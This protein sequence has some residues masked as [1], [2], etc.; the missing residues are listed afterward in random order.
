MKE[1]KIIDSYFKKNPY[2]NS[3]THIA[4]GMGIGVLVT[5]PL[6]GSHPVR[7]GLALLALGLAG[8]VYPLMVKK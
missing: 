6:V 1:L 8:H 4:V 7:W 2:L 3:V 5:Y